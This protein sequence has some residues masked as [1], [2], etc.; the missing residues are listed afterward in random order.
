MCLRAL[1]AG[2]W[3]YGGAAARCVAVCALELWMLV[4]FRCRYQ[5]RGRVHFGAGAAACLCAHWNVW[6]DVCGHV[7]FEAWVFGP[8]AGPAAMVPPLSGAYVSSARPTERN[9]VRTHRSLNECV[10]GG[11]VH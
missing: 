4:P 7:S 6:R 3:C 10:E 9:E 11:W 2:F 5:M 8:A 1:E